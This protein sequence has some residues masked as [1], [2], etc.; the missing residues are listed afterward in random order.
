MGNM[1]RTETEQVGV[2][3]CPAL[4]KIYFEVDQD[5]ESF[6]SID[7]PD[8]DEGD[9]GGGGVELEQGALQKAITNKEQIQ[10]TLNINH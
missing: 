4:L 3:S 8:D 5:E 1:M 7:E 2:P 9:V 10:N 6:E